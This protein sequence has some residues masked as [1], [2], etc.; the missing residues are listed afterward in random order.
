MEPENVGDQ[1][2]T[3]ESLPSEQPTTL[4][5]E[6][7]RQALLPDIGQLVEHHVAGHAAATYRGLQGLLDTKVSEIASQFGVDRETAAAMKAAAKVQLGD[8]AYAEATD[9][10]RQESEAVQL[11]REVEQLKA[12]KQPQENPTERNERL[13]NEVHLPGLVETAETMG[14]DL[15]AI[16]AKMPRSVTVDYPHLVGWK[17]EFTKAA[18]R[19]ADEKRQAEEETNKT[20]LDTTRG[21]SPR[22]K[23]YGSVAVRDIPDADFMKDFNSIAAAVVA[24]NRR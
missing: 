5:V 2:A 15:V 17:R 6:A 9:R 11:R 20:V 14:L 22:P 16:R 12:Q 18:N 3:G 8:D 7:I 23:D 1:G 10:G 13:W 4:T 24:K 21:G 19:L